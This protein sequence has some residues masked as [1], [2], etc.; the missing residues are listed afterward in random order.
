MGPEA[1][2][3]D[4]KDAYVN[5]WELGCKGVTIYRDGSRSVQVMNKVVETP[6]QVES[7]P[8]SFRRVLPDTRVAEV[9]KFRVGEQKVYMTVSTY[10]DGAPAELFIKA[11][12][13]GHT[14]SGLLDTVGILTSIALQYGVPLE[15]MTSKLRGMRFEPNGLTQ[16]PQIPTASS[17]P[18]YIAH[19]L[20][21]RFLGEHQTL[22]YSLEEIV[23]LSI[24]AGLFCPNCGA[25]AIASEGCVFCIA[26]C[27]WSRCG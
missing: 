21:H 27:G 6:A 8:R 18:D 25:K 15:A 19:W 22:T 24:D 26:G 2:I 17:I 10:P 23:A 16:N 20:E 11:A 1:T 7:T 3:T 13:E 4:V 9:H 14:I 5:A 12:K